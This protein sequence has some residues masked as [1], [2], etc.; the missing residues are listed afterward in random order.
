M[1]AAFRLLCE[2]L[3]SLFVLY[4]IETNFHFQHSEKNPQ[5]LAAWI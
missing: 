3:L 5:N 2:G 1:H 4:K